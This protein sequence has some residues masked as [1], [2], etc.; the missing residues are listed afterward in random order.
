MNQKTT[1]GRLIV[2]L[3]LISVAL[4]LL[5]PTFANEGADDRAKAHTLAT[6]PLVIPRG[7]SWSVRL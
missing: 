7:E 5:T 2:G 4:G 1:V 6:A 3:G